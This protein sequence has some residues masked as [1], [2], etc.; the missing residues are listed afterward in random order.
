ME[1]F[2]VSFALVFTQSMTSAG[3]VAKVAFVWGNHELVLG[4]WL[5]SSAGS[6]MILW[7]HGAQGPVESCS[8]AGEHHPSGHGVAFCDAPDG[9]MM[10]A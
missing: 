10:E 2:F 4:R 1:F 5:C 7:E 3:V 6:I 9:E 8:P